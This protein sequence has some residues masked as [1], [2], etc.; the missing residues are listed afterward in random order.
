M[1]IG[2]KDQESPFGMISSRV[3]V[4][5]HGVRSEGQYGFS[6]AQCQSLIALQ[7]LWTCS[8]PKLSNSSD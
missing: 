3:A 5:G 4:L 7:L 2:S 6:T 1:S 8:S